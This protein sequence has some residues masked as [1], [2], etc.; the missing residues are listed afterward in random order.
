MSILYL[1][2]EFASWHSAKKMSYPLSVGMLEGL[3]GNGEECLTL[4]V[5]YHEGIDF[6]L[7]KSIV[8]DRKFS[9][10][11]LEVVHSKLQPELLEW[12]TDV[13][14]IRVG[15][16][17]ESLTIL[18]DE[19]EN[20]REGTQRRVDNLEQKLPYLTHMLVTDDRDIDKFDIPTMLCVASVP[21]RLVQTPAPTSGN[22]VFYGTPYGE[23]A[24][25]IEQLGDIVTVNPPSPDS[26][27]TI[28]SRHEMIFGNVLFA[29]YADFFGSWYEARRNAYEVWMW[30]LNSMEGCAIIN[31]PHRTNVLSSRVIEGM[32]AGKPVIS[33]RMHNNID[34]LFKEGKEILLYDT[35][36]ELKGHI[37]TM[38]LS[39]VDRDS[40]A[41]NARF[42][43]LRDHTVEQRVAQIID[44][45]RKTS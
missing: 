29:E 34:Y 20:N 42:A 35:I 7:I 28:T 45:I 30:H 21:D 18:P 15:F 17:V 22:C 3:E 25:W 16:V 41:K 36:D 11:W 32:A 1:P 13:A 24:E 19:F 37:N 5:L 14:P 2:L 40:I 8:G 4:P 10:I 6:K 39:R 23:R 12:L 31:L 9:Q 26:S 38:S 33:P 44:F 27:A 43:V